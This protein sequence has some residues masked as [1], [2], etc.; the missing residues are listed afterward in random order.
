MGPFKRVEPGGGLA[1]LR[2]HA[3]SLM[4]QPL[5]LRRPHLRIARHG[6][7]QLATGAGAGTGLLVFAAGRAVAPNRA[8]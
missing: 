3:R 4:P 7:D 1:R 8:G 2:R 6:R 5:T